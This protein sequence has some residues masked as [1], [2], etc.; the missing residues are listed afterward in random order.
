MI[1]PRGVDLGKK[2]QAIH[3]MDYI[4]FTSI[5]KNIF[6]RKAISSIKKKP[7][8]WFY[9]K[10]I[11]RIRDY[12]QKYWFWIK[13]FTKTKFYWKI[14]RESPLGNY[15]KWQ[16]F[17]SWWVV[18]NGLVVKNVFKYLFFGG[19]PYGTYITYLR[20][21]PYFCRHKIENQT[22]RNNAKKMKLIG[23]AQNGIYSPRESPAHT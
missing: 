7:I 15:L 11:L 6:D 17:R 22:Y 18:P 4:L 12:P 23:F 5:I 2:S 14:M 20:T 21:Q 3:K 10:F 19:T 8:L 9:I 16:R 13:F 1:K